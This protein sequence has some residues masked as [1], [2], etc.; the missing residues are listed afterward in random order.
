MLLYLPYEIPLKI[1]LLIIFDDEEEVCPRYSSPAIDDEE[2]RPL[3]DPAMLPLT[4]GT[5]F[6]TA[7]RIFHESRTLVNNRKN[8]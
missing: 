2:N 4:V 1:Q 5:A 3:D 8:E 6:A 7:T